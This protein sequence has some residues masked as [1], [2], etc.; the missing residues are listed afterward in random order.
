MNYRFRKE[1]VRLQRLEY[2]PFAEKI[3]RDIHY[4]MNIKGFS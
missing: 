1:K 3:S 2:L 4:N